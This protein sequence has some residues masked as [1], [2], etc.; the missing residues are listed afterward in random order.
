M[1]L[2]FAT[3]N[4]NKVIELN[5]VLTP[6]EIKVL[7]LAQAGITIDIPEPYNTLEENARTKSVTIYQ[8]IHKNCFSE[9]TGLEIEALHGAPGVK[10]ARYA[11][12]EPQYKDYIDK[13]LHLMGDT[14][15]R[16]ARFRTV[17]SLI[18][19]GKETQ[20][21]GICNGSIA[22][23]RSGTKGFGYD[24]IFIPDGKTHTFAEMDLSE[25]KKISHRSK[26]IEQLVLYLK[27][28][29]S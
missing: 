14:P 19:N 17:I 5:A 21:E 3:N 26:A 12:N 22:T 25:K 28:I 29:N 10:S 27:N 9:D 7:S 8:L 13:V 11:D 2:I 20:F 1:E 15:N 4:A 23:E 24:P 18:L 16:K 6:S